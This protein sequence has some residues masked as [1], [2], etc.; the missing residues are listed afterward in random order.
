MKTEIDKENKIFLGY[1]S[2]LVLKGRTEE[3]QDNELL[4]IGKEWNDKGYKI[5]SG[6]IKDGKVDELWAII[7]NENS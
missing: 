1:L 6:K 3:E 5:C 4:R 7:K 2:E